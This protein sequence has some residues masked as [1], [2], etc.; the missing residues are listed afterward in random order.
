MTATTAVPSTKRRIVVVDIDGTISQIG[1]RIKYL[2]QEPKD[3]DAFYR[4]IFDDKPIP[5]MVL[6]VKALSMHYR[7]VFCSGR[8][9]QCREK[10]MN[11]MYKHFY[12]WFSSDDV[13]LRKDGDLRSDTV[14]KPELLVKAGINFEDIEFILEDRKCMVDKWR[15]LGIRCLQVDEGDF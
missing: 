1:D 11:W 8:R 3:W 13:L 14:V 5:E 2:Q 6:L 12:S 10:T 15:E 7:I 9:E 4:D